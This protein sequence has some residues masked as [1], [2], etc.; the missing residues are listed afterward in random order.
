MPRKIL[1]VDD[2]TASVR[3]LAKLLN[4]AGYEVQTAHS[5]QEALAVAAQ[6][7]CDLLITDLGLPD[8]TAV[9]LLRDLRAIS[10][11]IPAIVVTGN[12]ETEPMEACRAAGFSKYMLKPVLFQEIV[13]AIQEISDKPHTLDPP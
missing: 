5:R 12:V 10:R 7:P 8:G 1:V 4:H 3:V 11:A 6:R 9:E 2:D 13:S